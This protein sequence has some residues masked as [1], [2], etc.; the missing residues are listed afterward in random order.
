MNAYTAAVAVLHDVLETR[1]SL[2]A[3][4]APLH[5]LSAQERAVA[6]EMCFGVMRWWWGLDFSLRGLLG[7]PLKAKD[8]D[9]Y[10]L[11]LVGLYQLFYMRTPSH[12]AVNSAV[13]AAV[14]L[15]KEWAKGLV[16]AVL[17]NAL[18][19]Q[20]ALLAAQ[21]TDLA[22]RYS[23]PLWLVKTLQQAWPAQW[24]EILLANNARAPMTLRVN[25]ARGSRDDYLRKLAHA[26]IQARACEFSA[27]GIALEEACDVYALPGFAQ[28]EVSVQDEAAQFAAFLLAVPARARV[29]DACAAPGGK[30]AHL[31]EKM[32]GIVVHALDKSASRL[33]KVDETL[34]RIG[35]H[36]TTI[37]ADAARPSAW[38]DGQAYTHILLDAPCSGTGVIRRNPDIK[39]LRRSD[40]IGA[41]VAE[42]SRLLDTLWP[43]LAPGGRMLYA[44]CAVLP[45][46]NTQQIAAFLSRTADARH[47]ALD[48]SWAL[49]T[50]FGAQILPGM[51]GM[52]GFYYA[53]L[54]KRA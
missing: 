21:Q 46:E 10:C 27:V 47:V 35:A 45:E 41:L 9:V 36:A 31:L 2:S 28:G 26:N 7:K 30:T 42:Q 14:M 15:K 53:L 39:Y 52:D 5:N 25:A 11:L 17:R 6:Q 8:H 33:R 12:A 38:W 23:H 51:H 16:N 18:R 40:D 37:A 32:P 49:K 13:E 54:E 24:Q 4:T 1:R 3:A 43:L 19:Q 48:V 44:T 20:E 29:L 22:A 50:E 34:A